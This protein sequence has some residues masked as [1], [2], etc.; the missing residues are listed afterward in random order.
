MNCGL[1][2]WIS[3]AAL[4]LSGKEQNEERQQE[5]SYHPF[6]DV[7]ISDGSGMLQVLLKPFLQLSCAFDRR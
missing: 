6:H 2:S 1:V 5:E 3:L 7:L 4:H